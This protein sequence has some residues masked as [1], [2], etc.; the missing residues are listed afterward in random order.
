MID[1]KKTLNLPVTKFSMRGNLLNCEPMILENWY[2]HNLYK[3][4]RIVKHGKN[5]FFLHDGPPYANGKIHLGHAVNKV[6]KDIVVKSR[7]FMGYDVPYIPGWDCHGLPIELKVEES[8]ISNKCD[9]DNEISDRDFRFMCRQY[10]YTQIDQQKKDFIRLGVLGDWDGSYSTMDFVTEANIIRCLGEVIDQGY[11]YR[12]IKPVHWCINCCS[13][14][15]EAEV[16]YKNHISPSVYVEFIAFDS[17]GLSIKFGCV[18]FKYSISFIVWT[19]TPWTLPG[20]RALAVHPEYDYCLVK[21]HNKCYIVAVILLD[22]VIRRLGYLNYKLFGVIKGKHLEW[23]LFKHPFMSFDVPVVLADYVLSTVG[24]GVVHIAPGH[25]I[26]DYNVAQQYHLEIFNLID[27]YGHYKCNILS[28]LDNLKVFDSNHVIISLLRTCGALLYF[29]EWEHSYPHCWRHK[30]PIIFRAT[31]QW[32]ISLDHC[33]LRRKCLS[34][35]DDMCWIPNNGKSSMKSM[36]L[37]RPDWCISRQRRWGV[38]ITVFL[39]KQDGT[40]HPRTVELIEI[41]ARMVEKFGVQAWWDLNPEDIIGS[42]VNEYNRVYDVLDVWFDSGST[43]FSAIAYVRDEFKNSIPDIYLEGSDQ[44]RGWFMS[45]L[46][47]SLIIKEQS[48]CKLIVSH[49]FSVDFQGKKM[50]KSVGNVINPQEI[51]NKFGADVLRL[52]IASNDYTTEMVFSDENIQSSTITYRRIRNTVRFIL[53]NLSDFDPNQDIVD[54]EDMVVLDRWIVSRALSVQLDIISDYENYNFHNI[55]KRIMCFCSV[56][57]GS[58]YLDVIKDRQYVVKKNSIAR[59]SS[60]SALYHI[61][62]AMVRWIAPIISF[63]AAEIWSYIPGERSLHV[64]VEEWYDGLFS[65]DASEIMNENYWNLFLQI[66]GEVNK[67]LEKAR[68]DGYIGSSLEA[69]IILYAQSKL[70]ALLNQLGHELHF[71]FLTSSARVVDFY[72]LNEKKSVYRQNVM[73]GLSIGLEKAVGSK[74]QRCWHYTLDV[75]IVG[76]YPDICSR[77]LENIFGKG[78]ARMFI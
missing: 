2:N 22:D 72:D 12:G 58:F 45:A 29:E 9:C 20:N 66:R 54:P 68:E 31:F 14:L 39:H 67:V 42:D 18:N 4:L 65:M 40:L 44:Y 35:I 21:I 76:S 51:V 10:A 52:W 27:S 61:I 57:L 47:L 15:A 43:Y 23:S 63:T 6:L 78:E 30:T 64:F 34:A 56:E 69:G 37:N 26:E 32:F 7:N 11:L 74:C 1:Y 48:P 3:I 28:C 46:L 16:E 5:M 62:E 8:I 33:D 59:K 75:G 73:E 41:V 19:T 50:S 17:Y 38:P 77:C 53:G 24:T 55:V 71:G 13:V 70:S 49:G 25:G 60:Q 36:V